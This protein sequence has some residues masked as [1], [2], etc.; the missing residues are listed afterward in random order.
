[1][2]FK[3]LTSKFRFVIAAAAAGVA[4]LVTAGMSSEEVVLF[5]GSR[6]ILMIL[7]L[8]VVVMALGIACIMPPE[9]LLVMALIAAL[10]WGVPLQWVLMAAM[11]LAVGYLGL[12][13][14]CGTK[15]RR[16]PLP[17]IIYEF[18]ADRIV[19]YYAWLASPQGALFS[20]LITGMF[21]GIA[22][23]WARTMSHA[24]DSLS[25]RT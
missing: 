12:L 21:V 11:A 1:M 8:P 16:Q 9:I 13:F 10:M 18:G 2:K 19:S 5:W 7:C 25:A 6:I 3:T 14:L 24:V 22:I 17:L 20:G 15:F 4:T 23:L